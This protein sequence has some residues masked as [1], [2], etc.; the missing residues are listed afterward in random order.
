MLTIFSIEVNITLLRKRL[1]FVG[2]ASC[3]DMW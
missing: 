1:D 2:L 3:L